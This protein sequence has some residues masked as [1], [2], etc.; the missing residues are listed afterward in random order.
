MPP[1]SETSCRRSPFC[2]AARARAEHAICA[3]PAPLNQRMTFVHAHWTCTMLSLLA[4]L[5]LILH[6]YMYDLACHAVLRRAK[7]WS[8]A[9]VERKSAAAAE[10]MAVQCGP[11]PGQSARPSAAASDHDMRMRLRPCPHLGCSGACRG[12]GGEVTTI[13]MQLTRSAS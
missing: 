7:W 3:Y 12:E 10:K 5:R 6:M 11:E 9:R 13:R 4:K 8:R 2:A 1:S